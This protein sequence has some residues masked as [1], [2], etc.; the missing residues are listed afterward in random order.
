MDRNLALEFVR[1]T[2]VAAIEAAKWIG[3]G[4]K[5]AADQAAVDAMR[6]FMN[7]I[8][9][10]GTIVIG[11][12]K[13]DE[14]PELYTGEKV[15]KGCDPIMDIAVDPLECTDSVANGRYNAM[16]VIVA[17][18]QGCLLKAPDTYMDKIAVGPEAKNS[19]DL[20]APVKDNITKIAKALGKDIGEV[21]V[22]VLD[23]ERHKELIAEIRAVGARVRL[24]TD[25]D[26]AG[27]IAPSI[28]ENP[29]DVLMGVGASAEAVL[30]A[31]AIKVLGGEILCRFKPRDD[32]DKKEL[33]NM[34]ISDLQKVYKSDDLAKGKDITFTTT[35]VIEGPLL[36]GVVFGPKSITTYSMVIRGASGTMRYITAHHQYLNK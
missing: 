8:E 27:G 33:A 24:I 35:G 1:V 23:R 17:G 5:Q 12:G 31:A 20:D 6:K 15:G 34:G 14:A 21:T 2:E 9:F 32:E 3:R 29:I 28:P 16:S 25:G 30:A 26:V 18:T 11:E 22:V 36:P 4:D 10:S 19:I 7:T 13:K